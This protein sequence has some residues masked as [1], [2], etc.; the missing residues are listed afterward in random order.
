[1]TVVLG[2]D[3]GVSGAVSVLLE[4]G[5]LVT[6]FDVPTLNDG[7]KGRRTVNGPLL[8]QLIAETHAA[9]AYIEAVGPRPHEGSVQ[10]F[11]FGRAKGLTEGICAALGLSITWIAPTVWK[12]IV[13]IPPGPNKDLARSEAI[14][15]WP[16]RAE[17][18]IRK[19]DHNRAESAL[20]A[21]AGI[22]RERNNRAEK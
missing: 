9:R 19:R 17:L 4:V 21:L 20:I 7:P 15:R 13:N 8:A 10:S 6:S 1:M 16:A 3:L 5:E 12:R 22:K 18:F 14:R 11:A 2:V